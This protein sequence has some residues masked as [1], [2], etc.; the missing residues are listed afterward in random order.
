MYLK[1]LRI[2]MNKIALLALLICSA[3]V[4]CADT[5]ENITEALHFEASSH[6]NPNLTE[7]THPIL[8]AMVQDLTAAAHIDMPRYI[9]VHGAKKLF[10]T[11]NGIAYKRAQNITAWVDIMGDLHIC[12]EILTNLSH[13]EVKGIVAVAIAQKAKNIPAKLAVVGVSS[14]VGT[15]ALLYF[16]NKTYNVNP[17]SPLYPPHEP[18]YHAQEDREE[19]LAF[20]ILA[21]TLL[22]MKITSNLLQKSIDI[23][24][25]QLTNPHHV[26]G[27]IKG[28]CK[29]EETYIKEGFFSRIASALKL[30]AIYNIVFY[31]IRA[32]TPEERVCYL[33]PIAANAL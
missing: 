9:T 2:F 33:E 29:L 15:I 24:A 3:P 22:A 11:R 17:C 5:F 7:E 27:G 26:I 31:P 1:F 32:F 23:K 6:E 16:L 28:L 4:V 18:Y 20:L 10:V 12:R 19:A 8:Y 21:P 25:T 30:K 13:E 14:V